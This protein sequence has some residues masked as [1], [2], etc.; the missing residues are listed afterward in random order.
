VKWRALGLGLWLLGCAG[1]E[2]GNPSFDGT[3]GYDAHSTRGAVA[4]RATPDVPVVV[5]A[6]WLTLGDVQ[7]GNEAVVDVPGLGAGDHV[8]SQ[9]P[10]THVELPANVHYREVSIELQLADQPPSAAPPELAG[11]SILLSGTHEGRAFRIA[12]AMRARVSLDAL[13]AEGI[14]LGE[15]YSGV[16]F[17]FDLGTWLKDVPWSE[18]SADAD[19]T[20]LIDGEH[21]PESLRAFEAQVANG[22]WLFADPDGDGKLDADRDPVARPH[23]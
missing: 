2:T 19:G 21:S 14:S 10:V 6:A 22:I 9:A 17:G 1:T 5:Q 13:P 16:V 11:H 3:V 4:L 15:D 23:E 8:G 7:L 20:L 18:V 12:S